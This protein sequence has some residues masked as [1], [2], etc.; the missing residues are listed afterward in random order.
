MLH[1][2]RMQ[3]VWQPA[4]MQ[5]LELMFVGGATDKVLPAMPSR[6]SKLYFVI[7]VI[8]VDVFFQDAVPL[9]LRLQMPVI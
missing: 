7:V 2:K 6:L 4:Q 3:K 5:A 9:L 8:Q 1:Q